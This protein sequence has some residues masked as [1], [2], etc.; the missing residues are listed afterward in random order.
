MQHENNYSFASE[1]SKIVLFICSNENL[2]PF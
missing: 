1:I 2:I